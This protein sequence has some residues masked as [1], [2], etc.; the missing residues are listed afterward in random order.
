MESDATMNLLAR[1]AFNIGI[2]SG[3]M[4]AK[5]WSVIYADGSTI[6]CVPNETITMNLAG[7]GAFSHI[8]SIRIVQRSSRARLLMSCVSPSQNLERQSDDRLT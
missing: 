3:D 7:T 5:N 1:I 8:D 6:T 2:G 4:H